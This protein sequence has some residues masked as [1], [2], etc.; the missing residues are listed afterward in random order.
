[1]ACQSRWSQTGTRYLPVTWDTL[2][3]SNFWKELF[4]SM[5]TQLNMSTSYHPQTDGQTERLNRCL[6]QYLRAM[7]SHRPKQWSRWLP[8]AEWWY[9]S[10]YNSAIKRSP[11]EAVYGIKPRQM[12]IPASHRSS[13]S[14]VE[15]F[16]VS[17]EAM[18]QL[19]KDAIIVAQ[20]KYKVYV[21]KQRTEASFQEGQ[22]VYLKLQPYRQL[23]VAVRK[24]LKLAHKYFGPFEI[25]EKIGKVACKLRLPP[26]SLVHHVFHIRL[27]KKK[28][29]SK[30][31][32]TTAL[33]KIGAEGQ[34]LVQPAKLL[35][36]NDQT[37]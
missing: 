17:R 31:T 28:V 13:V 18:N 4:S 2:F 9:N 24:H 36:K 25:V 29:G 5:G 23:S 3:T 26:G 12:C 21:D 15:D 30:Y 34:F 8:L 1:M 22:M 6:E 32:I 7:V 19:L 20:H 16:Q 35:Q 10:T 33:P 37:W 14:S 27:L 11:F